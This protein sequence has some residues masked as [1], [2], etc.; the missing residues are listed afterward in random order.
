M[1]NTFRNRRMLGKI[2]KIDRNLTR[3]CNNYHSQIS[4]DVLRMLLD[5]C[6]PGGID[7]RDR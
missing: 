3:V 1:R 5:I 4:A 2:R 7:R 6:R